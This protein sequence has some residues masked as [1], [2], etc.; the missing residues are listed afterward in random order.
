MMVGDATVSLFAGRQ[1]AGTAAILLA[2][3]SEADYAWVA[4]ASGQ[5]VTLRAVSPAAVVDGC[6]GAVLDAGEL[7]DGDVAAITVEWRDGNFVVATPARELLRCR[8]SLGR[9]Q[10]GV[11]AVAGTALFD[12][13]TITR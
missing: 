10:V 8:P 3:R 2:W 12:D 11:G 1:G 13:L 4:L 7:P 6:S 5:P 9:G